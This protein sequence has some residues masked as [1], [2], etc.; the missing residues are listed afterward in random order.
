[1]E[2]DLSQ[3]PPSSSSPARTTPTRPSTKRSA[4]AASTAANDERTRRRKEWDQ[5][6]ADITWNWIEE[7]DMK[8]LAEVSCTLQRIWKRGRGPVRREMSSWFLGSRD[9]GRTGVAELQSG[10]NAAALCLAR[11]IRLPAR[12]SRTS[13]SWI[14]ERIA[15]LHSD[16]E[17]R[18]SST[19]V[20]RCL[21]CPMCASQGDP[22]FRIRRAE[23]KWT[24]A[25]EARYDLSLPQCS[26]GRG[27]W[28]SRNGLDMPLMVQCC[29]SP[30]ARKSA[31]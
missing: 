21:A 23:R 14:A 9:G 10:S 16:A 18:L 31:S 15:T 30:P 12:M 8:V 11:P 22:S 1:M 20:S 26:G 25:L 4:T 5:H 24:G 2:A 13:S 6:G 17:V 7:K 28:I 19:N 3:P 29:A 27:N